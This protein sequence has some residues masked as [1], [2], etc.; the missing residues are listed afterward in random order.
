MQIPWMRFSCD[1]YVDHVRMRYR[2]SRGFG[3]ITFAD[4]RGMD[5]AIRRC[6]GRS[7]VSELSQ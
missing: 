6:M 3:F 7:L 2:L 4:R 1:V 5:D